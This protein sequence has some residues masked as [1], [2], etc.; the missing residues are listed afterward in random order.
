MQPDHDQDAFLQQAEAAIEA[1]YPLLKTVCLSSGPGQAPV[2][3]PFFVAM[4]AAI[5]E[6]ANKP[7][8]V[9]LPE[10]S[11]VSLAVSAL[12]ALTRLRM[13]V[14]EILRSHAS[15]SFQCGD[16]VLV[17]PSGLVYEYQ[18]FFLPEHF[19][20]KVVNKNESRS[21]PVR[22][23]ARL[24]KTTRKM[25]RGQ[26]C[27]D[28]GQPQPTVLGTLVGIPGTVNRNLL[29][30]NVLVLGSKK[31]FRERINDW[32]IGVWD[33]G[34]LLSD[35]LGEVI[36]FGEVSD[37][38]G[39]GFFDSYVASGEPLIALASRPEDL[40][41][42]CEAA[43]EKTK[44]VVVDDIDRLVRSLQAYDAVAER[45]HLIAVAEE[46]QHESVQILRDRGCTV[47][48]VSPEEL[49]VGVSGTAGGDM[50][51]TVLRKA[52]NMRD[53]VVA[54]SPCSDTLLDEA[55]TEL[56]EAARDIPAE[57]DSPAVRELFI[58]LFG[59]LMSCAEFL[60][61]DGNGFA[62][63]VESRLQQSA[64]LLKR[65]Q[66]WLSPQLAEQVRLAIS[67]L[68]DA[69]NS[70]ATQTLTA[71]GS[72]LLDSLATA[73]ARPLAAVTRSESK[74]DELRAWM[75]ANGFPIPVYRV[76]EVPSDQDFDQLVLVA[77]PSA[78]R[79][80]RLL[81]QYAAQR[82]QIL[83]YAFERHW[84]RDYH[85][86]YQRTTVPKLSTSRK[87]VLL[88]LTA[89]GP[90]GEEPDNTSPSGPEAPGAEGPFDLPAERFLLRRKSASRAGEAADGSDELCDAYY[91][92]FVGP[93]FAYITEGHEL[94]IVN[95]FVSGCRSGA[96][97]AVPY[98]SVEELKVGDFVLF[99]ETGDS[100][101]IRFIAEDIVGA[102][103]YARM[104]AI[105]N[106]WR[107]A[108]TGLGS[109]PTLVWKQLRE[110]GLSRQL[111]TVRNW[112]N[113]QQ[114]IAPKNFEDVRL[115]ARAAGDEELLARLPEVQAASDQIKSLHIRAGFRLT[116]LL[117]EALPKDIEV[118]EGREIQLDL[119]FGT[120]WIV[121]VEDID[122]G[123][124]DCNR[125]LVNRLLWDK[126]TP[127][128]GGRN[129]S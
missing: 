1:R 51:R 106:S 94:P 69:A 9:V 16:R 95:A 38:G 126:D 87:S 20:L 44:S 93:T 115:I 92:D 46:T 97:A 55:A 71:K 47:W 37:S 21:L 29:R 124:T 110:I 78:K 118:P 67:K 45:Q 12:V 49:L 91:I 113:D 86:T 75:A 116:E 58:T 18:G 123:T 56:S 52:S 60:G 100:D 59:V 26:G 5:L 99:R 40:A 120:V 88:G 53:L 128:S 6:S 105:A 30:N 85:K 82:L 35:R 32:I 107:K 63:H 10:K 54:P 127:S 77:W 33:S 90:E 89:G 24:E 108:L 31:T 83:A 98:R 8:C 129:L 72:V 7:C 114:M 125:G 15:L 104:R 112:L 80:D 81:R 103:E 74:R 122:E 64:S 3:A 48:H 102:R 119:G 62:A 42:C 70:L 13:D 73:S 101:I 2:P 109:D 39:I 121:R 11:G 14:P 4:I 84:L 27:S 50:F 41:A 76:N 68:G 34:C 111:L 57:N 43:S 117:R 66:A 25:P 28:L 61:A 79:F 19:K 23:V 96:A 36:P 22:D 17:H 65:A